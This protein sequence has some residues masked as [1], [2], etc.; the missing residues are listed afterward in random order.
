M[1]IT[2]L[3]QAEGGSLR[4]PAVGV[5]AVGVA[6]AFDLSRPG[7]APALDLSRP[8]AAP[9]VSVP[10]ELTRFF[11]REGRGTRPVGDVVR[12]GVVPAVNVP[13]RP[14][15]GV[16]VPIQWDQLPKS[17][18]PTDAELLGPDPLRG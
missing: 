2:F 7:V 17:G 12:S 3:A 10:V 11:L 5:P 8:G 16:G 9:S 14:L 6:P 4:V 15:S 1:K 18:L 13:V